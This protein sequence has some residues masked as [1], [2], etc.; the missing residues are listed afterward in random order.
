MP[1]FA[2]TKPMRAALEAMR[3]SIGKVIVMPTPTAGPL[4]AAITGFFDSKM[5]KATCPPPSRCSSMVCGRAP[6]LASKVPLPA[7]RSAPAQ[8]ARPAPVTMITRTPSSASAR[9]KA[10]ISSRIMRAVKA[11]S[12]SGRCRVSVSDALGDLVAN[13]LILHRTSFRGSA[14]VMIARLEEVNGLSVVRRYARSSR[15]GWKSP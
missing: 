1:R 2:N 8:K 12:L 5:R 6:W 3:I 11:L 14:T 10:S 9:S 7:D 13:V 15:R 4:I